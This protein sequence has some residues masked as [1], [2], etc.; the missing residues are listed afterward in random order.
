MTITAAGR[1]GIGMDAKQELTVNGR[2]Y[3]ENGVIQRGGDALVSTSDLG[4][5]SQVDANWIRMVTRNAPIRFFTDGGNGSTARLSIEPDG[6]VAVGTNSLTAKLT[7]GSSSEHLQLLREAT[8]TTGG[9][10]MFLELV[11]IDGAPPHVPEV[12][13]CIRFHHAGRFWKRIEAQSNGFHLKEGYLP[14]NEYADITARNFYAN[15]QIYFHPGYEWGPE[16]Q[17]GPD[18]KRYWYIFRPRWNYNNFGGGPAELRAT[19]IAFPS[20][21][22]FKDDV[23]VIPAALAKVGQ[24]R[25]VSFAW[26]ELGLAHLTSEIETS[27]SAGPGASEAENRDLWQTLRE[28]SCADLAGRNIGLIAQEVEQVAPELVHTDAAG[29]KLVDYSRL[30][31][32]L[33]EA[34]KEQQGLVEAVRDRLAVLERSTP[35]R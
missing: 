20:D 22:R 35:T 6:K 13:P 9:P 15:G 1:V 12:S 3:L 18:A 31:A 28:R 24:L 8:E 4:L 27:V 32:V 10:Q 25:G 7:V 5:Y 14:S 19:G 34:I 23:S 17:F 2:L 26:N 29:Y 11:Q 16:G 33:V 21:R 30:A